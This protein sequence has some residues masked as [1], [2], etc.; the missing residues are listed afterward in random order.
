MV[1]GLFRFLKQLSKFF[2]VMDMG[3]IG[4]NTDLVKLV[5][6]GGRP[7]VLG[8]ACWAAITAVSLGLQSALEIW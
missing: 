8:A 3:A 1:N 7:I 4:L 2:I 5:R 6:T